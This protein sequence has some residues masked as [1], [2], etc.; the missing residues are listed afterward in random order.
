MLYR[1]DITILLYPVFMLFNAFSDFSIFVKNT[2]TFSRMQKRLPRH[3]LDGHS[4]FSVWSA[5]GVALRA[6]NCFT[7]VLV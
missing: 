7:H 2:Q 5:G 1:T 4:V 3:N 6:E